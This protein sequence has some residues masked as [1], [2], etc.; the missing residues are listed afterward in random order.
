MNLQPIAAYFLRDGW[1]VG[2]SGNILANWEADRGR[3]VWTVPIG[4]QVAKVHKVGKLPIKFTLGL[5]WIPIQ[6][7]AYGQTWNVQIQITPVIP[8]LVRGNLADPSSLEFGMK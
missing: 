2:Y 7:E 1:S 6:P 5:Q 4:A 8:K 3:D